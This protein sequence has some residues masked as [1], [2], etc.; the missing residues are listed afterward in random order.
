MQGRVRR[1]LV[2]AAGHV[3]FAAC[4]KGDS[5]WLVFCS[6]CGAYQ[7]SVPRR[8]LLQRIAFRERHAEVRL[9]S[10]WPAIDVARSL[11]TD[12][13]RLLLSGR[14]VVG[15]LSGYDAVI[16]LLRVFHSVSGTRRI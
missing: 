1:W 8:L 5:A 13:Q 9:R 10:T 12:T 11:M 3:L 7:Q 4:V 14:T 16:P 15:V 6:R 2:E